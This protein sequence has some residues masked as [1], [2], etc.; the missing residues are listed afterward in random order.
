MTR[1]DYAGLRSTQLD[2]AISSHGY[3]WASFERFFSSRESWEGLSKCKE[4][5]GE[6]LRHDIKH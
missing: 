3:S 4:N 6:H 2:V 5:A 1:V